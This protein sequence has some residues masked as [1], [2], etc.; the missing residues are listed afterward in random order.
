MRTLFCVANLFGF[1]FTMQGCGLNQSNPGSLAAGIVG[2]PAPE[3]FGED[4]NG[5]FFR[6]SDYKGKVVV[7]TFWAEW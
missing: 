2:R 1:L 3:L 7:L 6:L 4:V 5:D